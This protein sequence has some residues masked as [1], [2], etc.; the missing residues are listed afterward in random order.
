M[1]VYV[2]MYAC[3]Y[4]CMHVC[5]YVCMYVCMHVCTCACMHACMHACMYACVHI[6]LL[7]KKSADVLKRIVR[8]CCL[9]AHRTAQGSHTPTD[10]GY[11]Y[12]VARRACRSRN[13]LF[14]LLALVVKVA[15]VA[16]YSIRTRASAVPTA[17]TATPTKMFRATYGKEPRRRNTPPPPRP[18][19]SPSH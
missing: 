5:T 4:A 15:E 17:R 12:A 9:P 10:C 3:K 18:S 13:F 6:T 8:R 16:L 2:C 19:P 7:N 11:S 1:C 14:G